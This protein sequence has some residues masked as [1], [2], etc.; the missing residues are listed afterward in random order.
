MEYA[1]YGSNFGEIDLGV[2][3]LFAA[4][5]AAVSW[6]KSHN[7]QDATIKVYSESDSESDL[8]HQYDYKNGKWVQYE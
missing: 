6:I 5:R 4:K 8:V 3:G 1:L 7:I 2:Y